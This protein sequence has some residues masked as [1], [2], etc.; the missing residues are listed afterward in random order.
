MSEGPRRKLPIRWLTLAE[1]VGILA[2]V[3]AALGWWDN[4]RDKSEQER[5]RVAE[6]Q[7]RAVE[8]RRQAVKS[9]FLLVGQAGDE[10]DRIR[11][12]S[13]HPDQVIQ[14]QTLTFPSA[15]RGEPV[16]TTGNPRI[17]RGWIEDGLRKAVHGRSGTFRVPVG[18]V[19]T[20]ADGGEIHSDHAIYLV[21]ATLKDRLLR[22]A[23]VRLEGIS[24]ARRNPGGEMRAAV[25]GLWRP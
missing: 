1:L 7:A 5:E 4:H 6:Q 21:G 22:G 13:A 15:I 2:L 10:G 3:V 25:D 16:E 24:L 12:A 11:L 18:I 9:A 20:Y 23:A 19:T 14:S 17:D 8:A